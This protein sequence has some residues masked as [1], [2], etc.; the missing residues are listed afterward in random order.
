MTNIFLNHSFLTQFVLPFIMILWSLFLTKI[1]SLQ[2]LQTLTAQYKSW[3]GSRPLH[4][5]A[6]RYLAKPVTQV[7][8]HFL[9]SSLPPQQLFHSLY[10]AFITVCFKPN[11]SHWEL[12]LWDNET[13]ASDFFTDSWIVWLIVLFVNIAHAYINDAVWPLLLRW[14]LC[15]SPSCILLARL[16]TCKWPWQ[17]CSWLYW[18]WW[19]VPSH[20]GCRK[21][22]ETINKAVRLTRWQDEVWNGMHAKHT[23][24]SF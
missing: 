4:Y 13:K 5:A 17:T 16:P 12:G 6:T 8:P 1:T 9:I 20:Y 7:S 3:R 22:I 15:D 14:V 24:E 21:C 2:L 11:R 18:L 23:K 10:V 19:E